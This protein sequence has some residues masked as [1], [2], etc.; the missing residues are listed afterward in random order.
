MSHG[1][2]ELCTSDQVISAIKSS[3]NS[4]TYGPDSLSIFHLNNLGPLA[5]EH[6]T[7]LYNDSLK[8]CHIPSVWKTSLVIPI[9]KPG[10]DSSQGI[11]YRPWLLDI[12]A[13]F[14]PL[15]T[16]LSHQIRINTASDLHTRLHLTSSS[17]QQTWRQ[18]SANGNHLAIQCVWP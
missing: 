10:K 18:V 12:V 15:S 14:Y 1:E 9:P 16:N 2:S 8:F 11:S 3:R 7:S 6:H 4:R 5:R 17:S 13:R